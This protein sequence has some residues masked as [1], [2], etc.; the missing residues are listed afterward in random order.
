MFVHLYSF[1]V[2]QIFG[3]QNYVF[4]LSKILVMYLN[5]LCPFIMSQTVNIHIELTEMLDFENCLLAGMQSAVQIRQRPQAPP[6]HT[7]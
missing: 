6:K 4:C 5:Y 1:H 2:D 3:I 7:F